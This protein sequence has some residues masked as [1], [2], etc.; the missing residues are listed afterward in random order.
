VAAATWA[1]QT[2]VAERVHPENWG[3]YSR[4]VQ[5]LSLTTAV[6]RSNWSEVKRVYRARTGLA[7]RI[8]ALKIY[9]RH[10]QRVRSI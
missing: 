6:E 3:G 4:G 9:E 7:Y 5:K 2:L 10:T 8:R 1:P